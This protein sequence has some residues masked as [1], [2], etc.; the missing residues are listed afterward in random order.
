MPTLAS[1]CRLLALGSC[2]LVALEILRRHRQRRQERAVDAVAPE[3]PSPAAEAEAAETPLAPANAEP[4]TQRLIGASTILQAL[5]ACERVT[6]DSIGGPF[7]SRAGDEV[8]VVWFQF[9]M[10]HFS[11]KAYLAQGA[12]EE[13]TQH[14][15]LQTVFEDNRRNLAE[16]QRYFLTNE[17]NATKRYTRLKCGAGSLGRTSV[18]TLEY[19]VLCPSELPDSWGLLFLNKSL[20]MWYT[21]MVACVLHI[22]EPVEM[23]FATHEMIMAN[24]LATTVLTEDSC[25][26]QQACPICFEPFRAGEK[27]RRLPCMHIFHLVGAEEHA[28]H[29]EPDHHCN[30]DRH[31]VRDKQCPVCKTPIDVMEHMARDMGKE[32]PTVQESSS[33]AVPSSAP[34]GRP[35]PP[36]EAEEVA[37]ANSVLAAAAA[38]QRRVAEEAAGP[39]SRAPAQG[40]RSSEATALPAQAA[41]LERAVRSLQS[42]WMQIQDVVS[43]MQQMLHL[44]EDSQV[45]LGA[46]RAAA[47]QRGLLSLDADASE[48]PTA[49]GSNQD[50]PGNAASLLE[51]GEP[52]SAEAEAPECS[53]SSAPE[54]QAAADTE[55]DAEVASHQPFPPCGASRAEASAERSSLQ[56]GEARLD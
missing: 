23:P 7:Y 2:G 44:I 49:R 32:Q 5:Q 29:E 10:A 15:R 53:A 11:C 25:I 30:I 20:R 55:R 36:R 8:P 27:V 35:P 48:S 12:V 13:G 18:F 33:P 40:A 34:A 3:A 26:L 31:L 17:W 51:T 6:A 47:L 9:R 21:S 24:T 14:L 54:D 28:E 52:Q 1:S 56:E 42:R 39:S 50:S 37:G 19:D 38:L 46:A 22:V 43:G 4:T 16:E 45:A 41:E